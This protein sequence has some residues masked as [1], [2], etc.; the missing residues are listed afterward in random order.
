MQPSEVAR[1]VST[2]VAHRERRRVRRSDKE[3]TTAFLSGAPCSGDFFA[4][5][6]RLLAR[7][8]AT[9]AVDGLSPGSAILSERR[10]R[11]RCR[12]LGVGA[13]GA[14][15]AGVGAGSAGGLALRPRLPV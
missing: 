10:A 4:C 6:L 14:G 9:R 2:F 5:G 3:S 8:A 15:G 11:R 7:W 13:S 12:Q 1:K